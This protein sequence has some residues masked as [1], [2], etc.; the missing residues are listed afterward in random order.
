MIVVMAQSIW[1]CGQR[2][3]DKMLLSTVVLHLRDMYMYLQHVTYCKSCKVECKCNR[4][5]LRRNVDYWIS[6][7][8]YT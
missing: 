7:G 3:D 5:I 4:A 6:G 8:R 1:I 2:F